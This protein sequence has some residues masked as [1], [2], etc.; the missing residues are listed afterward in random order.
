M[1]PA[2]SYSNYITI[3]T[4][5]SVNIWLISKVVI[6][7]NWCGVLRIHRDWCLYGKDNAPTQCSTKGMPLQFHIFYGFMY[8]RSESFLSC[9]TC[10][11]LV[12]HSL[13]NYWNNTLQMLKLN[14][15]AVHNFLTPA[16]FLTCVDGTALW[17]VSHTV[18][19]VSPSCA[20]SYP[21]PVNVI[22]AGSP[23]LMCIGTSTCVTWNNV[24]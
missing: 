7:Q 20:L 23:P 3:G 11:L 22:R 9:Y 19:I 18:G 5:V 24:I 2:L 21:T 1:F 4:T 8:I 14:C 15:K 12:H 16:T 17:L 10:A 6:G 13:T